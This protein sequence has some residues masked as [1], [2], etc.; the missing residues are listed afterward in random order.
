MILFSLEMAV[1]QMVIR[2][3]PTEHQTK[4]SEFKAILNLYHL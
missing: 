3:E 1:D 2:G 4:Q